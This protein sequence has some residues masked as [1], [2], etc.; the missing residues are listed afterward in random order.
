MK[1]ANDP[2][3]DYKRLVAEGYN[4]CADAYEAARRDILHPEIKWLKNHLPNRAK[5][6]DIGCGSG[7]PVTRELAKRFEVTGVDIS[8]EQV[9]R[10]RENVRHAT[11][12]HSDIM[13]ID[14]P[15]ASFDAVV[16]MYAVFHLPRAEH[17]R[18]F[19]NMRRWL[20]P[21]GILLAT[22]AREAQDAYTEYDFFGVQMYWSNYGMR[23]YQ[24]L[25]AEAGFSL[26]KTSES[27]HGYD[28]THS[29]ETHPL[30]IAR[31]G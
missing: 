25:L 26:I 24:A 2:A 13:A 15:A 1:P 18:L 5:V 8:A 22:L 27:G 12:F 9:R 19:N 30:V 11:F 21:G 7:L 4:A 10:A 23:E 14:F 17:G 3:I 16:A 31:A 28:A 29:H 20:K 6:L